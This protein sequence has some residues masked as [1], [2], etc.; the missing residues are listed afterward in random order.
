MN[1]YHSAKYDAIYVFNNFRMLAVSAFDALI[2][3]EAAPV[4]TTFSAKVN[5][6]L[7]GGIQVGRVTEVCGMAG[8]GKTQLWFDDFK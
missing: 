7:G 8:L 5:K 6:L 2:K 1:S 3:E 4:I